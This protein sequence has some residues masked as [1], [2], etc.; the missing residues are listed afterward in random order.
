MEHPTHRVRLDRTPAADAGR[1][2]AALAVARALGV[3]RAEAEA[4]L[5][6]V[7]GVLPRGFEAGAAEQLVGALRAAGG[8]AAVVEAPGGRGACGEHPTLGD[9]APCE[10]CGAR[11]CRVC[12]LVR[13]AARCGACERA[14]RRARGFQRARVAVLLVLLL[15]AAGWALG[16][17][18]RRDART[19]WARPL[20]VAVVLVADGGVP[21]AD[22][23]TLRDALPRL[24]AWFA[25][26]H[27]R[28]GS[29]GLDA[30]VRLRVLGPVR[31]ASPLPWPGEADGWV[32][33]LRYAGRLAQALAPLDAQAGLVPRAVDARLY[34]V[35]GGGAD[36]G[37]FA[38]GVGEAGGEVGLVRVAVGGDGATLA[39]TALAHELLHCLGAS[40]KYDGAGHARLPQGLAD[41]ARVPPLPQARAEVMVGE[42]PL[43]PGEGRLAEDLD[44]VAVG[45]ATAAEVGWTRR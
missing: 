17:H 31:P 40:D 4:L 39:L 12:R 41:P 44:E 14:R 7:P 22:V 16:V 27:A 10:G 25:R 24:E 13:G 3:S 15:A 35:L 8:E 36:G 37:A 5:A 1:G 29:G 19:A 23:E 9:E 30:P 45:P 43:A 28:Y 26:E 33:R 6:D 42:V 32:A 18:R 21:A 2:V 20:E 11:T 38:E 34:A